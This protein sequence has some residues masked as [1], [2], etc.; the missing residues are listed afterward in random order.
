MS[1]WSSLNINIIVKF[2]GILL[3]IEGLFMLT[4]LPFSIYYGE[5]LMPIIYAANI[6]LIAGGIMWLFTR[7]YKDQN[8]GRREGFIMVTLTWVAFSLFG[9]LPFYISKEIPN[10][11]D[12]FF[13]TMSGFTTTGASILT[14][15]ESVSKGL[16]FWRSM[17]HWMGGMGIIVLSLAVLP[18]LGIGG[19]QLFIAEVPGP[20]PDK[21]HP[22]VTET[23]KR[24]WAIY[25]LITFAEIIFLM[26]GGMPFFDSIC[27]SFGTMATGGFSTKN[28]S[29]AG[30]SPYIQYVITFFMILAGMNFTLHYFALKRKFQKVISN[31]EL[32][33]YLFIIFSTV[34]VITI[35]LVFLSDYGV[36]KAFRDG[37]FQVVSIITT[38]GF[39]SADYLQWPVYLWFLIFLLMFIGGCAGSTGGGTKV[40][41]QLLLFKNTIL[42]LKRMI[43]PKAVIPVKLNKKNVP[44]E[45]VTNVMAFIII[46]VFIFII[47][48]VLMSFIGLDF[49]TAVGSVAA[50]LGNIGPGIGDVGPVDNYASIS[51]TGKWFLS[52]LMLLGRLEIFTVLLLITPYFWRK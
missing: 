29:I 8:V 36:E 48:S 21:L 14:D 7:N 39:V 47:S 1:N 51:D 33:A 5:N 38:T 4:A 42:E 19:M 43:H 22:R 17:T 12:A 15:I 32:K 49:E 40:A 28:D 27:H 44:Q 30:Y 26:F 45:I 50:T 9:A 25:V 10:Y 31:E 24:L 35:F 18:L 13:E 6:T 2:I 34:I 23:A 16:L 46:Y 11:T 52:L 41:R 20:V 37:I 3:V